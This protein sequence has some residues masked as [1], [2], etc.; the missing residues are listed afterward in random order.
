[1][2]ALRVITENVVRGRWDEVRRPNDL[3]MKA[4]S[5]M[6]MPIVEASAKVRTGPPKDDEPDYDLPVWAGVLPLV[7]RPAE[8][9][10]DPDLRVKVEVSDSVRRYSRV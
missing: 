4:T 6:K 10:P 3:E 8:P 1:M 5:V 2:E 9:V 7:T